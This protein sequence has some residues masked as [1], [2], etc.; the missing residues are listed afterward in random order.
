[1]LKLRIVWCVLVCALALGLLVA[2][3]SATTTDLWDT[4]APNPCLSSGSP[5]QLSLAS[6][7]FGPSI[8][9]RWAAVPFTFGS[10][11]TITD[12]NVWMSGDAT[13][14]DTVEY[15]IWNRTALTAPTGTAAYSGTLGAWSGSE[16]FRPYSGLSI[17]L[18]AGDYYF[19]AYGKRADNS[20]VAT[21]WLTG[22]LNVPTSLERDGI[23]RQTTYP[24]AS[25]AN[26][27]PASF[28]GDPNVSSDPR[29]LWNT[30][31][32]LSNFTKDATDAN[33]WNRTA[34][35]A[36]LW[37][38]VGNWGSTVPGSADTA[39][40][41]SLTATQAAVDL[42]SLGDVTVKGLS[43]NKNVSGIT[44]A[45]TSTPGTKL[46]LTGS[47][48]AAVTVLEGT[49]TI[50]A[51]VQFGSDVDVALGTT[52]SINKLT[53]AG[54]ITE[55]ASYALSLSGSGTLVL[56]G[57]NSHSG[58]TTVNSGTLILANQNGAGSG[59][60]TM[61][62]G[63]SFRTANFEGNTSAGALPNALYLSGG[64]PNGGKVNVDVSFANKDIWV[65]TAVA[66]PGGFYVT[67][68]DQRD[69]G[70]TLDGAKTF[71]G[72]VTL[73]TG[74]DVSIN[75]VASLGTGTLQAAGGDLKIRADLSA[76]AGVANAVVISSGKTLRVYMNGN[77]V[78]LSGLVTG[79]GSL[80]M[81]DGATLTLSNAGNRKS[82]V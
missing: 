54:D 13:A 14:A 57:N 75:N 82:V 81:N 41:S 44:I 80:L 70:L 69:Q 23:W 9:Q 76:G 26:W 48:P 2:P 25:F 61:A 17:A 21:G 59:T 71:G 3:V 42:G 51:P 5:T 40:F 22:G 29:Y 11:A 39:Y 38:D 58:G 7:N 45:D 52:Y 78:K 19:T 36:G 35:G 79:G 4:G 65:N 1:M 49:H 20:T 67:G 30:T 18:P 55:S 28:T 34:G 68:S 77:N 46:I 31:Y 66:G 15:A 60:L 64:V 16:W 10:A 53:I 33:A 8:P 73:G 62:G 6:G 72:G 47:S 32:Q 63:A 56:S 43:F 74:G 27:A 24:P 50:S 12:V 37:T